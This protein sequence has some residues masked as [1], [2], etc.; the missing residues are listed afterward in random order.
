MTFRSVILLCLVISLVSAENLSIGSFNVEVFGK[1]KMANKTIADLLVRIFRKYDL[2]LIQEI[3]DASGEA[4][5]ELLSMINN[6]QNCP[7]YGLELSDPLGRSNSK[8]QYGWFYKTNVI[9]ILGTHQSD[10]SSQ[11]GPKDIFE[12]PP[13]SIY[14]STRDG[15]RFVFSGIHVKPSDAVKEIDALTDIHPI[16]EHKFQEKKI[17]FMGDFNAG[18]RYLPRYRWPE[19]RLRTQ[20]VFSWWISD[21]ADTTVALS[22]CPYDRFVGRDMQ[23]RSKNPLVFRFDLDYNI[24]RDLARRVSDH[25]PIE[26][27]LVTQGDTIMPAAAYTK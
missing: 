8:E 12:R 26:F 15:N 13:H 16:L 7:K 3:R 5:Q 21:D 18:C 14:F 22:Q 17:T 6:C 4:V 24:H 10:W 1:T 19:I 20:A 25:W 27:T 2:A 11:F 9:K 23:G